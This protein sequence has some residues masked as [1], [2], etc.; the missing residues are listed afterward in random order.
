MATTSPFGISLYQLQ[1]MMSQRGKDGCKRL[2]EY[3]GAIAIADMLHSN[4]KAGLDGSLQDLEARKREYGP[5]YI[6]PVPPKSFLALALDAIQDKTLVILIV[7]ALLSIVLGVT[8]EEQ[9][10]IAWIE[11]AA[12]LAAVAL[13]VVVTAVNDWTK[14]RQFRGL[15]K[16]LDTDSRCVNSSSLVPS[17][18][19]PP[20]LLGLYTLSLSLLLPFPLFPPLL[21][22]LCYCHLILQSRF[23]VRR[24]GRTEEL[25]LAELVVGDV[26]QFKYGNTFPVDGVL[27]QV[28]HNNI[29]CV[30][31]VKHFTLTH[32]CF[33]SPRVLM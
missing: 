29:V 3:G 11:G 9:K 12:I 21:L 10:D 17:S 28:R 26:A 6:A 25:P 2:S 8:V 7:A 33:S 16:K 13:V 14:E 15:Q 18:F 32:H 24:D 31:V 19:P 5:N 30:L 1:D 23:S 22:G 27:I 4:I 20:L